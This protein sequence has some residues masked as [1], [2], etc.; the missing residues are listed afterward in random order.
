MSEETATKRV[1]RFALPAILLFTFAS[2]GYAGPFISFSFGVVNNLLESRR[3]DD[4]PAAVSFVR[5]GHAGSEGFL[6]RDARRAV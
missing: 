6:Y 1:T 4:R 3:G 5:G 2:A